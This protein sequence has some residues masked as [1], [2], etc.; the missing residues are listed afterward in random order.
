MVAK[1][2]QVYSVYSGPS[3]IWT[4][5]CWINKMSGYQKTQWQRKQIYNGQAKLY[6]LSRLCTVSYQ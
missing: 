1:R 2:L 4:P 6:H 5:L 3:I